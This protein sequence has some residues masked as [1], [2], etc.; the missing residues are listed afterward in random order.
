MYL[1]IQYVYVLRFRSFRLFFLFFLFWAAL[2]TISFMFFMY[3]I[4]ASL[5][6]QRNN[7]KIIIWLHSSSSS[8]ACAFFYLFFISW[9]SCHHRKEQKIKSV[10]IITAKFLWIHPT[11]N[12]CEWASFLPFGKE[13]KLFFCILQFISCSSR[14]LY[15]YLY[16]LKRTAEGGRQIL[17]SDKI[18]CFWFHYDRSLSGWTCYLEPFF[19]TFQKNKLSVVHAYAKG[20]FFVKNCF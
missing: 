1:Y 19:C 12:L 16:D 9:I 5:A 15:T 7:T 4:L 13:R 17:V 3:I 11:I 2:S 14:I 20:K 8:H 10:R 6:V 18:T